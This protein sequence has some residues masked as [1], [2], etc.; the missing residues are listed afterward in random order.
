MGRGGSLARATRACGDA[1]CGSAWAPLNPFQFL[2]LNCFAWALAANHKLSRANLKTGSQPVPGLR[3]PPDEQLSHDTTRNPTAALALSRHGDINI[4]PRLSSLVSRLSRLLVSHSLP[5]PTDDSSATCRHLN[6]QPPTFVTYLPNP[7]KASMHACTFGDSEPTTCRWAGPEQ[8]KRDHRNLHPFCHATSDPPTPHTHSLSHAD[9][10]NAR[11]GTS[12]FCN[13]GARPA[14]I[15][16]HYGAAAI[17]LGG[18]ALLHPAAVAPLER[19]AQSSLASCRPAEPLPICCPSRLHPAQ[20][21]G[22]ALASLTHGR[23]L[24]LLAP[25]LIR[26]V[27][28]RRSA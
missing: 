23:P 7:G 21:T 1:A 11:R 17:A 9:T 27:K 4:A 10:T 18:R 14:Q 15:Q 2:A 19:P 22:R 13:Y 3:E 24:L 12:A 5:R 8:P 20:L 25:R 28:A 16:C 26:R 6:P